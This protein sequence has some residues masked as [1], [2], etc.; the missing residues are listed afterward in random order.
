M[1]S[2]KLTRKQTFEIM[3]ILLSIVAI[4]ISIYALLHTQDIRIDIDNLKSNFAEI[5]ELQTNILKI[6]DNNSGKVIATMDYNGSSI[7][8]AVNKD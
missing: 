1:A 7:N 3:K 8:I 4:V 5:K 6:V 2:R